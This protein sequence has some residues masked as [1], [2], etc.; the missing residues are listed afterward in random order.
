M[1]ITHTR[2]YKEARAEEYPALGDQLDALMKYFA[3]QES[4]PPELQEWVDACLAVKDKYPK[5]PQ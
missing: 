4:I 1:I 5:Q 2:D 3:A